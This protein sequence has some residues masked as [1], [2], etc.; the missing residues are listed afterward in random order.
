MGL[1]WVSRTAYELLLGERMRYS[2]RVECC[3]C[4]I[5]CGPVDDWADETGLPGHI[6][7]NAYECKECEAKLDAEEA[8]K[9]AAIA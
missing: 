8:E 9:G 5:D 6:L 3:V 2:G 4:G 1:P 7:Q